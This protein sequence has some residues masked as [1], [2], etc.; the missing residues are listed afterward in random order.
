M[1]RKMH[2]GK[3]QVL[4]NYLPGRTFDFERIGV[5]AQVTNVRG[6]PCTNL[7]P[8]VV[9]QR[10]A[11]EARAWDEQFRPA[12]RDATLRDT[13]RFVLVDPKGV[14]ATF[15]PKVLW[16][17]RCGHVV[18]VTTWDC[19]PRSPRRCE[20]CH[21][22]TLVQLRFVKV[23]RCGGIQ[24]LL[25]PQ[26]GQCHTDRYMAL[27][28]RNSERISRFRWVC[29]NCRSAQ[30]VFPGYCRECDWPGE[31]DQRKMEIQVHRAGA[32]FYVHS[33]VLLNIPRQTLNA[34]L[35][36]PQWEGVVAAKYL[37][38]PQL[39]DRLLSEYGRQPP[40]Q[41]QDGSLSISSKD[42]EDL[43]SRS[44]EGGLGAEE[45][46][47]QIQGL[48]AMRRNDAISSSGGGLLQQVSAATAVSTDVWISAGQELLETIMPIEMGNP[49]H[50]YG[51]GAPLSS[52]T[53]AL[54]RNGIAR[55]SLLSDYP[56]VNAS[57]AFT[58]SDYAPN[59][60]R[61]CPFPP[62][63]DH[64]GRFPVYVDQVQAD[65]ILVTLDPVRVCAWLAANGHAPTI[66]PGGNADCSQLAYFVQLLDGINL[67]ETITG[68]VSAEA[69]FVF[70]L[71]HSFSHFCVRQAAL[72][73]GLDRTSLSEY[74]LPKTLTFAIYCNHRF[75]ATIGALSALF[76]QSLI[77]WLSAIHDNRRCVYDP[78]C[79]DAGGN[80]HACT[81]LAETSCRFFNLNLS[82]AFLFGGPDVEL[83]DI[84]VGYFDPSLP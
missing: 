23:H 72:L 22:N 37:K 56:I 70:G 21:E 49:K 80:C 73:C 44:T 32:T 84:S 57:Y 15:Y 41:V 39:A 40:A 18:D 68:A 61:L 64:G 5:I 66:P 3:Q 67:R 19:L 48:I 31:Q 58:R 59:Q 63:R 47:A 20:A 10:I 42:I 60:C 38:L 34:L 53:I 54:R 29:R 12:L 55:L 13:G 51:R 79:R 81:H 74:L 7:N 8:E 11:R 6:V 35:A 52:E 36:I 2:R 46:L 75:G 43:L 76:E 9:L 82:R 83:G 17:Q 65:A 28:T 24:P 69:R 4:F 1:G 25:P 77:E 27:E 33:T 45:M 50:V 30:P 78:V 62:H 71:L 14:E 26:C 16:C